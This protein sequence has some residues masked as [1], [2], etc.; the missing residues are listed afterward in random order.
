M[1]GVLEPTAAAADQK[2]LA[3][4]PEMKSAAAD[5]VRFLDTR[6]IR[7]APRTVVKVAPVP[8]ARRGRFGVQLLR[9]IRAWMVVP[10]VDFALMVAPLAWRPPQID[11]ILMMAIVATLLLSGGGRYV[12]RLHLSVLDELPSILTRLLTAVAAVAAA[13]LYVHQNQQVWIFL[14]TACQAVVLVIIGR[15][16]TT[17]LTALGRR[18]GI[19]THR[20]VVIGGGQVATELARILALHKEYGLKVDGFVDDGTTSAAGECMPRLGS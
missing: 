17:R 2:S 12:S 13:I 10:V 7:V 4:L 5:N 11:A 19:S 14:E 6:L 9:R 8:V 20:T 3:G 1:T 16:V 15:L 18:S